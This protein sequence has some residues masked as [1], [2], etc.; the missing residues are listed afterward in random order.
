MSYADLNVPGPTTIA[1]TEPFWAA[2]TEGRLLVQRCQHC[3]QAN[4]YPRALCPK[5]WNDQLDWEEAS[6]HGTLKSFSVV[7]KPGHPGWLPVAPYTVGLVV[8]DEG[9]ILL[10]LILPDERRPEVG[11]PLMLAPTNIGGRVLPAFR[12]AQ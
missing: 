6:G 3:G 10:S 8:L 5:C 4:L 1:L 11:L 7:H 2:A 9:L 12:I